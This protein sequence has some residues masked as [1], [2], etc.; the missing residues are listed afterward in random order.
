[1]VY[2]AEVCSKELILFFF[3]CILKPKIS[4]ERK[5]IAMFEYGG[6]EFIAAAA[7]PVPLV[8]GA[9]EKGLRV[10]PFCGLRMRVGKSSWRITFGGI[11]I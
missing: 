8:L 7:H 3:C 2:C 4:G 10:H 5:N 1:M 11:R 9:H 6:G